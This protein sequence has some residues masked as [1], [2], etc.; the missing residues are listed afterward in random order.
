MINETWCFW[1]LLIFIIE[2]IINIFLAIAG[3]KT[4]V[5]WDATAYDRISWIFFDLL[6]IAVLTKALGVW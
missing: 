6:V 1:L 4:N 2:K 3:G 5:S